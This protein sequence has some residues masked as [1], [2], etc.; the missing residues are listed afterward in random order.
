MRR[1]AESLEQHLID[2][3]KQAVDVPVP[4]PKLAEHARSG[5]FS[6]MRVATGAAPS[7]AQPGAQ[8]A[9][10]LGMGSGLGSGLEPLH[11]AATL[12]PG[13]DS[14]EAA[15]P[16]FGALNTASFGA[17]VASCR[18]RCE[19]YAHS[20]GEVI[21]AVGPAGQR[22]GVRMAGVVFK[23]S[24]FYSR[25][26]MGSKIW[27]RRFFV[28]HRDPS[29]FPLRYH[30][31]ADDGVTVLWEHSVAIPLHEALHVVRYS[32]V[33]IHLLTK[34]QT[35]APLIASDCFCSPRSRRARH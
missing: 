29:G 24:R 31:I 34:K 22:V 32:T 15:G 2:Q 28:L 7:T 17:L 1:V 8:S 20:Q 4:L 14:A 11:S 13:L 30:R 19:R 35:C 10:Q 3:G 16:S 27:Q 23:R 21:A 25:V 9:T 33:E 5:T 6:S 12:P 26:R 18:E